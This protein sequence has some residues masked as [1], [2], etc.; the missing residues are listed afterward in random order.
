MIGL[1]LLLL[2]VIAP[3]GLVIHELGHILGGALCRAEHSVL[4]IGA[5]SSIIRI[6]FQKLH[7][8]I[9]SLYFWGGHSA[10]IKNPGFTRFQKVL[11]SL[12]GPAANAVVCT[13]LI[14][15]NSERAGWIDLFLL[16]NLYLAISNL[17]P[18][19]IGRRKSDGYLIF[20]NLLARRVEY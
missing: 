20:E 18:F 11:I 16:F 15:T 6:K 7:I 14:Y 4:T 3:I 19:R 8:I 13:L 17:I 12:G 2:F 10:N 9:G 5:G 1:L